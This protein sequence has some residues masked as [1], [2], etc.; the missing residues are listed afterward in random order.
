MINKFYMWIYRHSKTRRRYFSYL[1]VISSLWTIAIYSLFFALIHFLVPVIGSSMARGDIPLS[2]LFTCLAWWLVTLSYAIFQ[3][4]QQSREV[5]V[6][7]L[8][9]VYSL[10]DLIV[11]GQLILR[12]REVW[13]KISF[14]YLFM[15]VVDYVVASIDGA[16]YINRHN[17][18]WFLRTWLYAVLGIVFDGVVAYGAFVG[19]PENVNG[20]VTVLF[21]L[22]TASYIKQVYDE[23]IYP[24]RKEREKLEDEFSENLNGKWDVA[25][26]EQSAFEEA[27]TKT[28]ADI[29]RNVHR[30]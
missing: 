30:L 19:S 4:S 17:Q 25:K 10:L 18:T 21:S 7:L 2:V 13:H 8:H 1:F 12:H 14:L 26:K 5:P 29:R 6:V 20:A 27:T 9:M 11:G 24:I 3:G 15:A 16:D 28:L 22:L 23:R